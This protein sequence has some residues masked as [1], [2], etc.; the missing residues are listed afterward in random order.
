LTEAAA[1]LL[2]ERFA[3]FAAAFTVVVAVAETGE[4]TAWMERRNAPCDGALLAVIVADNTVP[5]GTEAGTEVVMTKLAEPGAKE[6]MEQLTVPVVPT[7]GVVQLQPRGDESDV[8]VVFGSSGRSTTAL[9]TSLGPALP[10]LALYSNVPPGATGSGE[11][12]RVTV[13]LEVES[14]EF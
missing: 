12:L 7:G 2:S 3:E 6:E 10:T 4:A 8:K 5:D 11:S 1:L 13:K 14:T 9:G